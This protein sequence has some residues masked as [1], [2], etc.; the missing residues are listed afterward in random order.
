MSDNLRW[1]KPMPQ[2]GQLSEGKAAAIEGHAKVCS[3]TAACPQIV[4]LNLFFDGTNNNDARNNPFR[5]SLSKGH[6]NVARLY[7]ACKDDRPKGTFRFYIQGPGT[8]FPEI[9]ET[10]YSTL[11]KSLAL[12]FGMRVGWGYT[13][14]LNGLYE[15]ITMQRNSLLPDPDA[16]RFCETL[17]ADK[18]LSFFSL[19][20]SQPP[21]ILQ[22]PGRFTKYLQSRIGL[23]ADA[24][25]D[26]RPV[27]K[28]KKAWVNVFGF[29]RGAAVARVFVHKFVNEWAAGGRLAGI[30]CEVNFMGLF[31]TVA[32][33]GAPESVRATLNLES[34]DGHWAWADHGALDIPPTVKRCVHFFSIH[35]QRRSFPLDTIRQ[36]PDYPG[37]LSKRLEVAYPGVHS[38]VGGG[39]V[40]GDQ[41]KSTQGDDFKLSNIAL[42][43]MYIEALRAGVPLHY[44]D[45]PGGP[46]PDNSKA[47][48]SVSDELIK[49]FNAWLATTQ[50]QPLTKV[51]DA[52]RFGLR[53]SLAWR[54]VR[55]RVGTPDYVTEQPFYKA[56]PEDRLTPHGLSAAAEGR[57]AAKRREINELT[58]R[59]GALLGPTMLP[60]ADPVRYQAAVLEHAE[61][62]RQLRAKQDDYRRAEKEEAAK[63]ETRRLEEAATAAD[64][65]HPKT[66]KS[67]PGEGPD[68]LMTNDKTDLREAAEEFRLLLALLHPNEA[69]KS[70]QVKALSR[71]I[72]G[73]AMGPMPTAIRTVS[74]LEVARQSSDTPLVRMV[75]KLDAP[76]SLAHA[77]RYDPAYDIVVKPETA[78]QP[79]LRAFTGA[80]A[81]AAMQSQPDVMRLFDDYVH[82]SRAWFRVPHFRELAQGGYG[83][84]R[85]L[86]AGADKAINPNATGL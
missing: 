18:M 66:G 34:F 11:G 67:R 4:H 41:G 25:R 40:P 80:S 36:G 54:A 13:S 62:R 14:V 55:A 73:P 3:P 17:D 44:R 57:L 23:L 9:G 42:H 43:D 49:D 61:L 81:R 84:A 56:A 68:E 39:Y 26:A 7:G 45:D 65:T 30:P 76:L 24:Q 8:P 74:W 48:F 33:V 85:V 64:P 53:Q 47:D 15:A 72:A 75:D 70:W 35:E 50:T 12:G 78:T 71:A 6:T 28:I 16:R 32:S 58:A 52:L 29:S 83:W 38:D 69:S 37:G 21:P 46:L 31:D 82:D 1:P 59:I 22:M 2:G 10:E 5:D 79:M 77:L 19:W 20:G 60:P 27:R 51:E 63:S 86:F